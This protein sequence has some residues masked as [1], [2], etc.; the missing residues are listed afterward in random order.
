MEATPEY[1]KGRSIH[2]LVDEGILNA[3]FKEL[4]G[5]AL[6]FDRS[7]YE[8]QETAIKKA[9]QHNRNVVVSTGTGSGKTESFLI[10]IFNHLLKEVDSGSIDQ[11]G[12][13]ALLLYPMNALANDQMKR[14]RAILHEYPQITFGRYIGETEKE[15][16]YAIDQFKQQ[17][18]D[19]DIIKN[20]LISRDDMLALSTSYSI[21]EL[22]NV[23]VFAASSKR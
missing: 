21:D 15:R 1:E 9:V 16:K 6:P 2:G 7:L 10:P 20:E 22:C 12:V 8:H 14:L 17:F 19:E 5:N 18:P 11:P 3:R 13:R 4:C 23:G